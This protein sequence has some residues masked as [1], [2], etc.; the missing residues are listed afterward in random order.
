MSGVDGEDVGLGLGHFDGALQEV[1][2]GADRGADAQAALIVFRGARI[3]ELFL[4][5]F[6]GDQ[7]FEVE[8]LIDDEKFFDAMLLQDALGFVER[9]A[10]GN[11]DEI[12]LGHHRAD[13]LRCDFSRSE[14]RD[15]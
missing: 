1:A 11:G 15:W 7:A 9:G 3:F 14:D 4:D 10:D 12:V 13:E 2:G 8:V 6:Y 5:V